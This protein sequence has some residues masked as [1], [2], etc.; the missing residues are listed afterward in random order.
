MRAPLP[1]GLNMGPRHHW[2]PIGFQKDLMTLTMEDVE[3]LHQKY[4]TPTNMVGVLV[5]SISPAQAKNILEQY[6][7]RTPFRPAPPPHKVPDA[8]FQG[9]QRKTIS[10]PAQ[11]MLAIGFHKP[12]APD[13]AD[14]N[15]DIL[16]TILCE[17]R[18]GRLYQHL[19]QEKK[20]ASEVFCSNGFP[21]SRFDNMFLVFAL[22][23][24][25][26]ELA[27]LEKMVE[28]ELADMQHDIQPKELEKVRKSVLYDYLWGLA[29]PM[30]YVERL[31]VA[32]A[33]VGD[34]R[35]VTTYSKK[36]EAITKEDL[37]KTA[38]KYF[39]P[40]NRVVLYRLKGSITGAHVAPST[41]EAG[42]SL[43]LSLAL[44]ATGGGK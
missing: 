30:E 15:F 12:K 14:Y 42:W 39:V 5:G 36:I 29:D 37:E 22:P 8:A 28:Q 7:G 13:S 31:G 2:A 18:T 11:P 9:E 17:G 33:V 21:G 20:V 10:Y 16:D 23:N 41:G 25:K 35:Y 32:Q 6:F 40:E 19:V 44:R 24:Q 1:A 4:Y 27:D 43:P 26:V 38:R 3:A 34:W